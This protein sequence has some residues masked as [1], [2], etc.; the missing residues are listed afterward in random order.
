MIS[1]SQLG[2]MGHLG[3][4]MF[5]YA[6]LR[7]LAAKH[8]YEWAIPAQYEFGTRYPMRSSMYDIFNLPDVTV[9]R[10]ILPGNPLLP[11]KQFHFDEDLFN[12]CPDNIDLNGYYQSYKY[13][14]HIREELIK[15][16]TFKSGPLA[17][18][19]DSIVIHVRRGDYV[20]QSEFH[21]VCDL[22]YY[23]KAMEVFD[24]EKFVVVSDDPDWCS[25][26][27]VFS[28]CKIA[29]NRSVADDLH[30]MFYAKGNIIANSSFSWWGA[31]LNNNPNKIVICPQNWFGVNYS[32]Y[33]MNDLRPKEWIQL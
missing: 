27:E 18:S 10:T 9:L 1:F 4:Q 30:T 25:E 7:G 29:I 22:D 5:Q 8:G 13:F 33:N 17:L 31:Y 14:D 3:N 20:N 21:P 32:H 19:S 16:F 11:E 28:K 24:G 26:Q 6:S 23:K 2:N 12:N 15:E